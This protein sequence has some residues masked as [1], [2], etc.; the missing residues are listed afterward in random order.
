MTAN[1]YLR[2]KLTGE[3]TVSD[4]PYAY[5]GSSTPLDGKRYC[6]TGVTTSA[7]LVTF[8]LPAGYFTAVHHVAATVVRN[9]SAPASFGFAFV[10]SQSSTSVTVQAAESKTTTVLLLNTAVEGIE[11]SAAGITVTIAVF[12]V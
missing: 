4:P 3:T 11:A 1:K 5:G 10:V 7:G 2:R 12:G 9:T 6:D 8:T